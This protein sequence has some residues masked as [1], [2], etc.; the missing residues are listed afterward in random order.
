MVRTARKARPPWNDQVQ[1]Y[2]SNVDNNIWWKKPIV[3]QRLT[4]FAWRE[5]SNFCS[6]MT[7]GETLVV[8]RTD[9]VPIPRHLLLSNPIGCASSLSTALGSRIPRFL[10]LASL[11]STHAPRPNRLFPVLNI[12]P[13]NPTT[14]AEYITSLAP[15]FLFATRE[16]ARS[17]EPHYPHELFWDRARI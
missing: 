16:T 8:L 10:S 7:Y 9:M 6:I 1:E 14:T 11:H 17:N 13:T 2:L 4:H 3:A 5:S 15:L 12:P